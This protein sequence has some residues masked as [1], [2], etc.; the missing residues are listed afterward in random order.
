M[1]VDPENKRT[2]FKVILLKQLT[3]ISFWAFALILA[4][5]HPGRRIYEFFC[6]FFPRPFVGEGQGEGATYF[7][8]HLV[9]RKQHE[10]LSKHYLVESSFSYNRSVSSLRQSSVPGVIAAEDPAAIPKRIEFRKVFP[11]NKLRTIPATI[12]SPAPTLLTT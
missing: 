8:P 9:L 6:S 12:L 5:S 10:G 7:H 4:F 1:R 3:R 11:R 2:F